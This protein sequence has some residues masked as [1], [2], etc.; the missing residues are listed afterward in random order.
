MV[1]PEFK[2]PTTAATLASTSFCATVVPTFGSAWSSSL[3]ILKVMGLPSMVIFFA[4]ASATA[5]ATPFSSS[6]PRWAIE[7]VRGPAWAMVMVGPAGAAGLAVAAAFLGSSFWPQAARPSARATARLS[8]RGR[9][10]R[11]LL[12]TGGWGSGRDDGARTP[13][14]RQLWVAGYQV[15]NRGC[16]G[17]ARSLD[18]EDPLHQGLHVLVLD[19]GVGRHGDLAPVADPALLHLLRQHR[20]G[21]RVALV[22]PCD[23]LVGGADELLLDRVAGGARILFRELLAGESGSGGDRG[24]REQQGEALHLGV[25][26]V[27]GVIGQP[28]FWA[29]PAI[30]AISPASRRAAGR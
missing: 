6:F 15:S 5:R 26:S 28:R 8:C 9:F 2:W 27:V 4:L 14:R 22:F 30:R 1:T 17:N 21:L 19:A 24:G 23:L 7:P 16:C 13:E 10:M 18:R 29:N 25:L 20:L 12:E 11:L 3:I